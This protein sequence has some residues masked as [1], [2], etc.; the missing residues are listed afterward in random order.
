LSTL[1]FRLNYQTRLCLHHLT[2]QSLSRLQ[3]LLKFTVTVV[4]ICLSNFHQNLFLDHNYMF[5]ELPNFHWQTQLQITTIS[6]QHLA[7]LTTLNKL[8]DKLLYKDAHGN[9]H[10]QYQKDINTLL[11][12]HMPIASILL[13]VS[14][15]IRFLNE[16]HR[17]SL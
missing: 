3:C 1:Q 14:L 5:M 8:L 16:Q 17:H 15:Q 2:T 4:A 11:S 10:H 9:P 7:T 6:I 13:W 12:V